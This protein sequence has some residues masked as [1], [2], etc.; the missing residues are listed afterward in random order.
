MEQ[1][2]EYRIEAEPTRDTDSEFN[3]LIVT[4]VKQVFL[5]GL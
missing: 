3:C 1:T 5:A 2:N 4:L